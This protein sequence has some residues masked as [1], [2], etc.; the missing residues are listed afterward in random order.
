MIRVG[1]LVLIRLIMN[2]PESKKCA[3]CK[4]M[5]PR[6]AFYADSRKLSGLQSHCKEC[7]LRSQRESRKNWT[8]E[9]RAKAKARER[10]WYDANRDHLLAVQ[11]VWYEANREKRLDQERA[12]RLKLTYDMTMDEFWEMYELQDGRCL[13]CGSETHAFVTPVPK[14]FFRRTAIDHDSLTGEVRGLL[15]SYCNTAIGLF[16]HDVDRLASAITYLLDHAARPTD[17]PVCC[18]DPDHPSG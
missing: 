18:T 9:D 8:D 5:K 10:A 14:G 2:K 7:T 4:E 13:I 17:L 16:G 6:S 1:H 3:R 15:C 12:R 11:R